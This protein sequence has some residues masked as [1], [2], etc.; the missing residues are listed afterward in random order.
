MKPLTAA[1]VEAGLVSPNA[2]AEM[3]RFRPSLE[4]TLAPAEPLPLDEAA[5]QLSRAVQ[6]DELVIRETDL[7]A[8]P[9]YLRTQKQGM[10]HLEMVATEGHTTADFPV[11]YG[12][13][14]LG[15]FI[16]AWTN[17]SI[18]EAMTNGQTFLQL[19][20]GEAVYFDDV[21]ELYYDE[22]KAFMVCRKVVRRE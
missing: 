2:L 10:L 5:E 17:D 12:R 20:D 16:I 4:Q 3:Q 15:E 19:A 6:N 21:R 18:M 8:V 9:T 13:T 1:V 14:R 7:D 22:T 11:T